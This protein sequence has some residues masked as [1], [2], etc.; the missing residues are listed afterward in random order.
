[1]QA[2]LKKREL[3]IISNKNFSNKNRHPDQRRR[4]NT[5]L[6]EE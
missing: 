2:S 4:N 3:F 6:T 5:C 1:M